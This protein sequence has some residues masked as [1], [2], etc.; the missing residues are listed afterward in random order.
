MADICRP[1]VGSGREFFR[2]LKVNSRR[3]YRYLCLHYVLIYATQMHGYFIDFNAAFGEC[4]N[5]SVW[6]QGQ[7]L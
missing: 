3:V 1:L 5:M 2:K 4:E 6:W 7:L